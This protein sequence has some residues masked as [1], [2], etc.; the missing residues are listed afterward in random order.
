MLVC[1]GGYLGVL[2]AP[3]FARWLNVP[4]VT[5][6]RGNDFD[7]SIFTPRKRDLL[8]D[9]FD[10]STKICSVTKDKKETIEKFFNVNNVD[11]IPNGI[12]LTAWVPSRSEMDF[13]TRWKSDNA[14]EKLIIGVFGQLKAK[15]GLD[16][17]IQAAA[18][19]A[20]QKQIHLLL[21]GEIAEETIQVLH[22]SETAFSH[23]SFMDRYELMPYYLC[24]D[25][26]A[27]PSFYD[28]MPNVLLEAGA[29]SIPVVAAKVGG[30]KDLI[31]HEVSGLL[32]EPG[33]SKSCSTTLYQFTRLNK[34]ERTTL[35]EN[36]YSKI[37]NNYTSKHETQQY[38]VLFKKIL[39]TTGPANMVQMH[40]R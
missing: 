24:C 21:I 20:D 29:L 36:L 26:V 3:V 15:K 37:K 27:I 23:F 28:G 19:L 33:D 1:F 11:F 4:L 16:F 9:L 31:E 6:I 14:T 17:F 40:S 12:D 35:G 18:T 22:D 2:A 25:C 39:D 8:K 13:A 10:V 32:F 5:M 7:T 34:A 38:E 30:M